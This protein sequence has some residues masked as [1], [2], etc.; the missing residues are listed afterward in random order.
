M[1]IQHY[2]DYLY[3]R[4]RFLIWALALFSALHLLAI[5]PDLLS[6]PDNLLK[7]Q[8]RV[9]WFCQLATAWVLGLRIQSLLLEAAAG[10]LFQP[11]TRKLWQQLATVCIAAAVFP[12]T[13]LGCLLLYW[14]EKIQLLNLLAYLNLPLLGLGLLLPFITGLFK[15]SAQL[16]DEQNLTI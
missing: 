14:D 16:E 13:L 9:L 4:S 3:H 11:A 10:K 12:A 2:A 5:V 6:T 15:L 7:A 1:L 8:Q